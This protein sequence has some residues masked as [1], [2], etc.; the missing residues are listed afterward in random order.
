MRKRIGI[1]AAVFSAFF[2]AQGLFAGQLVTSGGFETGDF[3]GWTVSGSV[4]SS[5]FAS[6]FYGVDAID[7]ATGSYGAYVGSEFS[8]LT[9]SQKLTVVPNQEYQVSFSLA[10][11]SAVLP[12]DTNLFEVMLGSKTIFSETNAPVSAYKD[13]SFTV[14]TSGSA[15]ASKLLQITSENDLGYFS[16]DN[17]SVSPTPEPGTLLLIAPAIGLLALWRRKSV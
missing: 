6:D 15:P 14:S 16:L 3:T 11:S 12:G 5:A 13:Y 10:Q 7:A 2:G 8:Q 4:T 9:L 17:V 1:L